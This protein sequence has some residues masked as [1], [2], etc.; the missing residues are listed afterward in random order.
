ESESAT[1][2]AVVNLDTALTTTITLTEFDASGT[3]VGTEVI[4][5]TICDVF[6]T[7]ECSFTLGP[8]EHRSFFFSEAITVPEDM[9]V[10]TVIVESTDDATAGTFV[11]DLTAV[12]LKFDDESDN[13]ET[14]FEFT[15]APVTELAP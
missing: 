11:T 6:A 5:G 9:V 15:V 10:G 4:G 13:G 1:G 8:G 2:L 12:A 7:Q 3:K 14:R